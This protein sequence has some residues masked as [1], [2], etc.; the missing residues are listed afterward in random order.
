MESH[1]H[2][3]VLHLK[4][5]TLEYYGKIGTM[6]QELQGQFCRI[7]KG[8]L[9]NLSYVESYDRTEVTLTSGRRLNLSKYKYDSFV[10]MHLQFIS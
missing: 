2:K 3:I 9:V 6:E 4:D 7:H 10:K 1:G 8:Y 5:G